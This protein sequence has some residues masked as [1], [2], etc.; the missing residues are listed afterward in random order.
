M[1]DEKSTRSI[2]IFSQN[3]F[4][5]PLFYGTVIVY[6]KAINQPKRY[7]FHVISYE[8]PEFRRSVEEE[9]QLDEELANYGIYRYP[10]TWGA[11]SLVRKLRE[12]FQGFFLARRIAKQYNC[13]SIFALANIAGA[14][15]YIISRFT[16]LKCIIFTYEPHSEFMRD[17][18]VWSEKSMKYKL[19]HYLEYK[20]G[21]GSAYIATGTTH[22]V[23][24]L[25]E[26]K[27]RA[28]VYR[29]PSCIDENLFVFNPEKRKAIRQ[30]LDIGERPVFIYAGKFGDLYYKEEIAFLCAGI[31]KLYTDAFFIILTPNPHEEI[32][33]MFRKAEIL[34]SDV[35]IGRCQLQEMP[36]WLSVADM[37]IVAVPPLPSQKF[38]SPIKV[39]EYLACGLPYLVC[40]GVSEDDRWATQYHVGVVLDDFTPEAILNNRDQ[41]EQLLQIP[42]NDLRARCRET[43]IAYRSKKIAIQ[44]FSEIF[45]ELYSQA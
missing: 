11:G 1:P 6:L 44:A 28:K 17:C 32:A 36:H 34:A 41:I 22:M 20:M 12:L 8:Q 25:K 38:R 5:D 15:S 16:G 4:R 39:G 43:G 19:L 40:K 21:V 7:A 2:L 14:F 3:S 13:N 35:W 26:W 9:K 27:S 37:G 10:L 42:K 30:Q 29:V 33:A 23:E 24:R 45:N 31:Q 18:G